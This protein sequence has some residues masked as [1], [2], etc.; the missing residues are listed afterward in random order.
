MV[1]SGIFGGGRPHCGGALIN[2][3]YVVSAAHCFS[4][5]YADGLQVW[6][7]ALNRLDSIDN[8]VQ[9]DRVLKRDVAEI[10]M[11]PNYDSRRF[12]NDIAL[13]KLAHPV[14]ISTSSYYVPACLPAGE[15]TY[16][17]MQARVVGWGSAGS[18]SSNNRITPNRM[19]RDDVP[20]ISNEVCNRDTSHKD[21]ITK[22]HM[23]A[24]L[25]VKQPTDSCLGDSG[26]PLMIPNNGRYTV[27]GITSHGYTNRRAYSPIVYT[28]LGNY[29]DWIL[30]NTRDADWCS[31]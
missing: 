7:T 31:I 6:L 12:E 15:S 30:H 29:A 21:R 24:G 1:R 13:L 26:G 16:N 20:V 28:R 8:F 4:G 14:D 17:G 3:Q 9:S 27:I 2:D 19:C 11:H 18:P 5:L 22:N 10:I 25:L 23:C